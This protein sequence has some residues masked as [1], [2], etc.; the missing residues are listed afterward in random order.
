MQVGIGIPNAELEARRGRLL[1]HVRREGLSG[2]VLF[3][4]DY[5]RY[6]TSFVFTGLRSP[7]SPGTRSSRY[8]I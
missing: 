2:Y 5:I 7:T 1:E 8:R 3:G 6:F 4:Q